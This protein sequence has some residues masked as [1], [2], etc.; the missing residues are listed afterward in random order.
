[1]PNLEDYLDFRSDISFDID[2]F[3]E[4]DNLIFSYLSY[5]DYS[6]IV[7]G[8]DRS[9]HI[10]I[11]QVERVF[12]Q[13]H[14]P[15]EIMSMTTATKKAPFILHKMA[16]SN[17]YGGTKIGYYTNELVP[18]NSTQFS[19]VSF[20]LPDNTV[21]VG[22][23]GTDDSL[24]GWQEDFNIFFASKTGGQ[25]K[26][27]QYLNTLMCKNNLKIRVG[28]HSK[29]GN[30]A[31]YSSA[32]CKKEIQD[33]IIEIYS[34]DGPGFIDE[35]IATNE[36]KSIVPRVKSIIPE[37][38]IIGMM[39]DNE[40]E[41]IVIKGDAA[42]L[43]QHNP[44]HWQVKGNRFALSDTGIRDKSIMIDKILKKWAL[45]VDYE[46][47]NAFGE[48]LFSALSS[49]GATKLS[50]ITGSKMKSIAIIKKSIDKL[51]KEDQAVFYDVM[52][53]LI[54]VSGGSFKDSILD[55]FNNSINKN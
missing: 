48:I 38:S 43:E 19:A 6:G 36:Y 45:D 50:E 54:V 40:F 49:G 33:R 21:Y 32:F 26:A 37:Q 29:G 28:G 51:D 14:T 31:V 1:M 25:E 41:N 18:E 44:I 52:K 15:E 5:V 9:G 47:R 20:F 35:I 30:F 22:F 39:M 10:P 46:T 53:K 17:R 2:P 34:N 7:P 42:G 12:F 11:E 4:V 23:R 55:W 24:V 13:K 16:Y 3:N 27:V 8:P